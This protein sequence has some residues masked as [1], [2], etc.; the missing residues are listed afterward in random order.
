MDIPTCMCV[1]VFCFCHVL[2]MQKQDSVITY[3]SATGYHGH[4]CV[5]IAIA[6]MCVYFRS[7]NLMQFISLACAEISFQK[8]FFEI[9]CFSS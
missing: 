5:M 4:P 1:Y 8:L 6:Y 9:T 7:V 2:L 3:Y